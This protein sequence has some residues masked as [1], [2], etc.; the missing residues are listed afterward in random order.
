MTNVTFY[1]DNI[2][3]RIPEAQKAVFEA[4]GL[5]IQQVKPHKW[6]GHGGTIDGWLRGID[7]RCAM[8]QLS[9]ASYCDL[10]KNG[11]IKANYDP[12]II[13]DIDCIP[14]SRVIINKLERNASTEI[15]SGVIQ[16]ASHIPNSIDYVGPAC[17]AFTWGLYSKLGK[18][19]FACTERSD[20][21][22]EMTHA[23]LD[24][25][26]DMEMFKP[27]HVEEPLWKLE[28][29]SMFGKGTTFGGNE[30][31]YHAFYSRKG[32][33]QPFLRKCAEV[34]KNHEKN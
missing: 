28:D 16:H 32:N 4:L 14:L 23:V 11:V 34:I 29:G 18:P 2:D 8:C 1:A 17:M 7:P 19:T 22:G 13:W 27:T 15:F 10:C 3:P 31:I 20:C 12:I 5:T 9:N 25:G 33:I 26:I 6:E 24:K 21:G 30:G